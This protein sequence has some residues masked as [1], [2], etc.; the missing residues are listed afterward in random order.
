MIAGG[1][2]PLFDKTHPVGYTYRLLMGT[3]GDFPATRRYPAR[4]R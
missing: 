2:C 4:Q 3:A 1:W